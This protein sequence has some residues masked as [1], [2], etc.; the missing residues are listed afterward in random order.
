MRELP[1]E[2]NAAQSKMVATA[3]AVA[4]T[5]LRLVGRCTTLNVCR[6]PYP[7]VPAAGVVM[8]MRLQTSHV[9]LG[10]VTPQLLLCPAASVSPR[11]LR[12][13]RFAAAFTSACA[14]VRAVSCFLP[15][16]ESNE[17]FYRVNEVRGSSHARGHVE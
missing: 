15:V 11:R 9:Q 16:F 8:L 5:F 14:P 10:F 6:E 4:R 17:W 3:I 7:A 1:R 12:L 13:L 2:T